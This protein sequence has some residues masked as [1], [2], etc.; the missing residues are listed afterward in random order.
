MKRE[1]LL[2][3]RTEIVNRKREIAFEGDV[4]PSERLDVLMS[5]ISSG[6]ADP[7]LLRKAYELSNELPDDGDRL[8]A[9][10]DL[11]FAIDERLVADESGDEAARGAR[12]G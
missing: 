2:A 8:A 10:L 9:L 7:N 6:D 11:I 1:E 3:L 4:S 5:L 12:E